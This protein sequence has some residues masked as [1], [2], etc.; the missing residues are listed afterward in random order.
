MR[1]V[2]RESDNAFSPSSWNSE[3][4]RVRS[5]A[6]SHVVVETDPRLR[7]GIGSPA[8]IGQINR[9]H[10][11]SQVFLNVGIEADDVCTIKVS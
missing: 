7:L 11:L 3:R 6:K 9:G 8:S 2:D 10:N 5:R 1:S 4:L